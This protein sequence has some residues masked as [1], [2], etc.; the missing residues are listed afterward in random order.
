MKVATV[1]IAGERRVGQ[2]TDDGLSIAPFDLPL[3]EAQDGVV[4]L[5]RRDGR[6]L[7]PALSSIPMT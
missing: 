5:I 6:G 7:P 1:S 3:S 4:A 2:V